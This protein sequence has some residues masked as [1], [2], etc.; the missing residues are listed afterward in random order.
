MEGIA[1]RQ[2]YAD[3]PPSS[4]CTSLASQPR[5]PAIKSSIAVL[6]PRLS[7]PRAEAVRHIER[8]WFRHTTGSG[9]GGRYGLCWRSEELPT[10]DGD[11]RSVPLVHPPTRGMRCITMRISSRRSRGSRTAGTPGRSAARGCCGPRGTA[12]A[13]PRRT[14]EPVAGIHRRE[15]LAAAGPHLDQRA[16]VV[17]GQRPLEVL[18]RSLLH[19]PQLRG[20]QR[21]KGFQLAAH[22]GVE[23]HE[24]E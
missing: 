1:G 9:G 21:G 15:R 4:Q 13:S 19:R 5:M 11:E 23:A 14:C 22:L 20:I 2:S 10:L 7:E 18:D 17:L 12:P 6:S 16:G 8:L 24:P 3:F